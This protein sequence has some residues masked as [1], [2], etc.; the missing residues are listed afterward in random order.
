MVLIIPPLTVR[1][2]YIVVMQAVS[3]IYS[4]TIGNND[5]SNFVR[6][7]IHSVE[8]YL[9]SLGASNDLFKSN[10]HVNS[11][12]NP[13]QRANKKLFQTFRTLFVANTSHHYQ[14][15]KSTALYYSGVTT[16]SLLTTSFCAMS[17]RPISTKNTLEWYSCLR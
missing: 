4:P 8:F 7:I 6:T 2:T 17:E 10:T 1:R 13:N 12:S 11:V 16:P 15:L 9:L 5:C 14:P 3:I